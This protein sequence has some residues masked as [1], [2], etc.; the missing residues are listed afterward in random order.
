MSVGNIKEDNDKI[1]SKNK[2]EVDN[3]NNPNHETDKNKNEKLNNEEVNDQEPFNEQGENKIEEGISQKKP[4][5]QVLNIESL[6]DNNKNEDLA[7]SNEDFNDDEKILKIESKQLISDEQL[8]QNSEQSIDKNTPK[9]E[10]DQDHQQIPKEQDQQDIPDN[11]QPIESHEIEKLDQ[12]E[13]DYKIVLI[14]KMNKV[15]QD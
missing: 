6:E 9:K 15:F 1:S 7:I 8:S 12:V 5:E 4:N 10:E 11:K 14:N 3:Q 2:I 13:I